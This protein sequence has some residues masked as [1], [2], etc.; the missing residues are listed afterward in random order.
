M[1]LA[2]AI[3]RL[4]RLED[5]GFGTAYYAA[6]VRSMLQGAWLFVLQRLRSGRL[7]LPRQA[8]GRLLD[9]D[10]RRRPAGLQRL[11]DPPAAGP[12]GHRLG[13]VAL[14]PG[15]AARRAGRARLPPCCWR[16]CRSPSPID[17]S[18]NTDSWLILFLLLA[19]AARLA[20]P[21]SL[22]GRGDGPA[23]RG[24][25]HQD[26]GGAG[27][28]TRPARGLAAGRHAR[29]AQ[30]A[31]VDDAAGAV[32]LAVV[33]LAWAVAFDLTPKDPPTLCRQQPRQFHARA[34]RHAQRA[35]ALRAQP[36]RRAAPAA[37]QPRQARGLRC[38]AG[39]PA[40]PG[41][42]GARHAV[43][44]DAAA[45]R[46]GRRVRLAPPP[47]V[48]GAVERVGAHLRH[49][50]QPGRR[51][52]STPTTW[53]P[54][55]RR[56]RRWPASAASSCGVAARRILP[57]GSPSPLSGRPTSPA[58]LLGWDV[59]LDRLSRGRAAGGHRRRCGAPSVRPP[60]SAASPCWCCRSLWALSARLRAGQS[61]P[62]VGQPA[63]LAGHRRWP[64]ADPVAQ[65]HRA[66]RRSQAA[67]LPAATPRPRRLSCWPR[68]TRC[69]PHRSSS[70]PASRSWRSVASSAT[71]R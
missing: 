64:R 17:R 40:A 65:L 69:S 26:A 5:N 60:S 41:R 61:H 33:S 68:P 14:P 63:A 16:S 4:L 46:A 1:L 13:G 2:A 48:G 44:L 11:D 43:R 39:R 45:G 37:L 36:H 70:A 28:R 42:S 3:L 71:I 32:T 25:Q 24:F 57:W 53:R 10:H 20:W 56:S 21:R 52:S 23:G 66:D 55:G 34:D 47:R 54:S 7:H 8:A 12:G 30:A 49:R 19:A 31:A 38:R 9:P 22:A 15:A 51:A 29:L 59:D 18:N 27:V 6:G 58:S 50:L 35:G 62:A 67:R